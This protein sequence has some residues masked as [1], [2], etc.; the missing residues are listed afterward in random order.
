MTDPRIRLASPTRILVKERLALLKTHIGLG[1]PS[2]AKAESY[3]WRQYD[4]D[5]FEDSHEHCD[6]CWARIAMG[7]W[8]HVDNS[9]WGWWSEEHVSWLCAQC[10]PFLEGYEAGLA[11]IAEP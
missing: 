9:E 4:P 11:G 7:D 10:H 2:A 6:G 3:V 1:T 5:E 8:S